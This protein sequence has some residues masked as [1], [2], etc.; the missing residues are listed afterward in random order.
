MQVSY[1]REDDVSNVPLPWVEFFF[2]KPGLNPQ[3][4]AQFL[5][6]L[7]PFGQR[8]WEVP[9][10]VSLLDHSQMGV[11]SVELHGVLQLKK[12]EKPPA[13]LIRKKAEAV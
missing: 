5:I 8:I 12:G 2:V 11:Y 1:F 6:Q 9:I 3:L 7:V 10:R 4:G 13:F